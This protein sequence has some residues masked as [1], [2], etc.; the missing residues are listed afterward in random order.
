MLIQSLYTI[1][2]LRYTICDMPEAQ[3]LLSADI[4]NQLRLMR[5]TVRG[6]YV[7]RGAALA[8][9]FSSAATLSYFPSLSHSLLSLSL[10]LSLCL[11]LCV[12]LC[13][14]EKSNFIF[15]HIYFLLK[16][17]ENC[18]KVAAATPLC[19]PLALT[20]PLLIVLR[21]RRVNALGCS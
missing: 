19:R 21:I 20:L 17:N 15:M 6:N 12:C 2:N 1:C 14:S 9:Q 8:G 10:T 16:F 4:E 18:I 3:P 7:I 5:C 13:W 11:S